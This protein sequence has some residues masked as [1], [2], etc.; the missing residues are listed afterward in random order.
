MWLLVVVVVLFS[1]SMSW[2]VLL[3]L[4][5]VGVACRSGGGCSRL[6]GRSD[7]QRAIGWTGRGARLRLCGVRASVGTIE[8]GR[9]EKEGKMERAGER[10]KEGSKSVKE[11][12]KV[13]AVL[14]GV[15]K[16]F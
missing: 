3:L 9:E 11:S 4:A 6:L 5:G 12:R 1:W 14:K 2:F 15:Y 16:D 10:S 7:G 13:E 8:G